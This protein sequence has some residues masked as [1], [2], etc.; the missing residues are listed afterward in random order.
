MVPDQDGDGLE[1]PAQKR[2]V[3][4]P[5]HND[6][7]DCDDANSDI[8]QMREICDGID[9]DCDTVADDGLALSSYF[10]DLM[11]TA[12]EMYQQ[13]PA[14]QPALWNRHE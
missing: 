13:P 12:M 6:N 4:H 10:S 8:H 14:P 5:K 9:N 3:L 11:V 2:I 7:T 1:T